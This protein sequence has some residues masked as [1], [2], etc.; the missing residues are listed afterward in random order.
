MP[1]RFLGSAASDE[2][3]DH[4]GLVFGTRVLGMD[5]NADSVPW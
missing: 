2:R 5:Y 3:P 4:H 1:D